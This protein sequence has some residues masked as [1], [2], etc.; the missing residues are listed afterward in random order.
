MKRNFFWR[1]SPKIRFLLVGGVNT[2]IGIGIINGLQFI[3]GNSMRP[4]Y[5]F[6]I[7]WII[8][9]LP[10]FFGMQLLVFESPGHVFAKYVKYILSSLTNC[11]VGICF[12]FL[13]FD[14]LSLNV[15]FS[16]TSVLIINAVIS[17]SLMKFFTF[18]V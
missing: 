14:L 5:V 2:L 12:L 13:F 15:Y 1:L 7:G 9:S 10:N 6:I 11:L 8:A 3:I 17:Y 4:Q 18:K 16:Q